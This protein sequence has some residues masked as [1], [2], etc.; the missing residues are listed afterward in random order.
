MTKKMACLYC[1]E[2]T[3]HLSLH[4]QRTHAGLCAS[5]CG[6]KE[7][8]T[9]APRSTAAARR[10]EPPSPPPL[11]PPPPG[12]SSDSASDADSAP[13]PSLQHPFGS[14]ADWELAQLVARNDGL[15]K[16]LLDSILKVFAM[17]G[18][19]F[20]NAYDVFKA[21]DDLDGVDFESECF[22]LDPIPGVPLH[23]AQGDPVAYTVFH[24]KIA[25]VVSAA[26]K[27]NPDMLLN[28]SVL[29]Q[30]N[31]THLTEAARYQT[32]LQ[33]LRTS[34]GIDDAVLVPLLFHSGDSSA[35]FLLSFPCCLLLLVFASLR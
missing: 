35:F 21:I 7:A 2:T 17:G 18:V 3:S 6:S 23:H 5:G 11:S 19:T 8:P 10:E 25:D 31:A 28:P 20:S 9:S 24:R 30:G 32:L 16:G 26:I 12:D 13:Q 33:T 1:G 4:G 15:S 22:S 27:S 29:P 14:D 34:T